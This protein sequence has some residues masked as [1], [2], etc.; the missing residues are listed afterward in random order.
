[1]DKK[2]FPIYPLQQAG[3]QVP[4]PPLLKGLTQT[5]S[6]TFLFATHGFQK[7]QGSLMRLLKV[8][9]LLPRECHAHA[10]RRR[11]RASMNIV[12]VFCKSL[13]MWLANK[14]HR[15]L[16]SSCR[17]AQGVAH[18]RSTCIAQWVACGQPFAQRRHSTSKGPGSWPSRCRWCRW[19]PHQG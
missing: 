14:G 6:A 8:Q 10:S 5:A 19:P 3:A 9:Q 4:K 16:L 18:T 17:V 15:G 13:H 11:L 1:M 7:R 2:G 12:L